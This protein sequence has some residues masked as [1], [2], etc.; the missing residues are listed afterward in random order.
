MNRRDFLSLCGL[1]AGSCVIPAR[2]ARAIRDTCV[3]GGQPYF[4]NAPA[5]G[6]ILYAV[7]ETFGA[8]AQH[9][10]E[11]TLRLGESD[12]PPTWREYL[13]GKGID[14]GDPEA[15][16]AWQREEYCLDYGEEPDITFDKEI[17]REERWDWYEFY[18]LPWQSPEAQAY[19]YLERLPL[20]DGKK[21]AGIPLGE[22]CFYERV[23]PDSNLTYVEAPDL[24][25]LACLQHRLNELGEDVRIEILKEFPEIPDSAVAIP[26]S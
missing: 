16:K 13:E 3:L 4:I 23:H 17:D 12:N 5:S 6:S 22:L 15:V 14:P 8:F 26:H 25:T 9:T 2:L 1:A 10:G 11:F 20:D 18:Y 7:Q 24:E 19:H 21:S